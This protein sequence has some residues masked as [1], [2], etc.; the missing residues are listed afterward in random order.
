MGN[1][2][3]TVLLL[4]LIFSLHLYLSF[5]ITNIYHISKPKK[6]QQQQKHKTLLLIFL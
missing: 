3:N 5:A 4:N 1:M 2:D 6:Q